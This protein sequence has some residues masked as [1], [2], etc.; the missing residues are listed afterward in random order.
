MGL[1]QFSGISKK[2]N[3]FDVQISHTVQEIGQTAWDHMAEGHPFASYRWYHWGETVLTDQQ[4]LYVVLT[5]DNAP[6]AR[7]TFW[8]KTREPL[9][10]R[11][12][13][14][15]R[16]MNMLL[17]RRPLLMCESPLA[18]TSG[19]LLPDPPLK[20]SA[21]RKLVQVGLEQA[22]VHRASFL[23][24]PYLTPQQ[25]AAAGW[26]DTFS[27]VGFDDPGTQLNIKWPH[28]DDYLA[29]LDKKV[30]KHYRRTNRRAAERGIVIKCHEQVTR[31]D[32]ALTLIDNVYRRHDSPP[33]PIIKRVLEHADMV[34]STWL[35]A[36][37]GDQLVGCE[38][39]L[40]DGNTRFLAALGL[41]YGVKYVYFKLG[42]QD[43]RCAIEQGVQVLRGGGSAYELKTSWGFELENNNYVVFA[44][45]GPV[46]RRIGRWAAGSAV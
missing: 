44:G 7:A 16:L 9:P 3:M 19:L 21:L 4:P 12:R 27:H 30:R 6:V 14:A 38:L 18:L 42:Y 11:S 31:L 26:S 1:G 13:L 32:E 15:R 36:E 5:Q 40:G 29:S 33:N 25:V 28:F 37:I 22:Q 41:D 45:M 35:T 43:I 2:V 8:L 34:A 17:Q 23:V 20:E 10:I 39:M 24:F 46:L